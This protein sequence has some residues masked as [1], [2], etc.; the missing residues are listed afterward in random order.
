MSKTGKGLNTDSPGVTHRDCTVTR[1][2]VWGELMSQ[3]RPLFKQLQQEHAD[4]VLHEGVPGGLKPSLIGWI[5]ERLSMGTPGGPSTTT[6]QFIQRKCRI[7]SL[8]WRYGVEGATTS[9]LEHAAADDE[10]ALEV[11]NLLLYYVGG[12]HGGRKAIE[13]NFMLHSAGS[14]WT[15]ARREGE[16][17]RLERRVP[18]E[19][20]QRFSE[21]SANGRAGEHLRLSWSEAYGRDPDASKAYREAVRAVEAAG[22]PILSPK[23]VRTTL[24]TMIAEF[25]V[26]PEKWKVPLG[27]TPAEGRE[28]F[29]KLMEGIWHGQ[30]DRHGTPDED[31]P[32]SVTP[33]EAEAALHMALTVVHLFTSGLVTQTEV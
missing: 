27:R 18:Q 24:G 31:A 26:K 12:T 8:D 22:A 16:P 11:A 25:R 3:W 28:V 2:Y 33:Q 20:A 9:L 17:P 7:E 4:E 19:A 14:A 21:V 29:L 13:L 32:L 30:V 5:H 23:N 1:A 10:L 15:V 6:V